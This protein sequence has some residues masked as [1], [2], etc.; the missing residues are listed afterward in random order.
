MG[1]A[2]DGAEEDQR[3]REAAG[4]VARLQL[5]DA[6]AQDRQD[7]AAWSARDP[8]N[9]EAYEDL[10]ALWGDLKDA[11]VSK[12]RLQ[13]LRAAR[14]ARRTGATG[15]GLVLVAGWSLSQFGVI[16]CLQAD[17]STGVGEITRVELP[18]GSWATL[19]TDTALRLRF[20]GARRRIE[21]L[22]GEAYF[23]VARMPNRPFIATGEALEATALGTRFAIKLSQ[24]QAGPDVAVEEGHVA[25]RSGD[26]R[27]ELRAGEET[28]LD[29]DGRL[30]VLP[31]DRVSRTAWK[32]GKLVFSDTPLS[33][34]LSTLG[35]YRRG[36][37]LVIDDRASRQRISGVFDVANTDEALA[38]LAESLPISVTRVTGL[39]VL[40][41]SR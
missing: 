3:S 19:N 38:T 32:D 37:I 14:R 11:P 7:F 12:E 21:L 30:A 15:L 18:D 40:V 6:T 5:S 39:L 16:D 4:W 33:E 17:Y 13:K 2:D 24:D 22:R 8:K 25:V 29:R 26:A 20:D 41:R 36:R 35:R 27:I 34:V 28:T 31:S 23:E 1:S 9:V 10:A